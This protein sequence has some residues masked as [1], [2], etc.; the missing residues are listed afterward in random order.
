MSKMQVVGLGA[1]NMDYLY[2]VERILT[3]GETVVKDLTVAPG[4]SAANT[5]YGL[6]KLGVKTGFVGAVGDDADG[7]ALVQDFQ[8]VGIDTRRIK[9]KPKA[10]SGAVLCLTDSLGRRS[11]Y[12]SPGANSLLSRDDL[13]LGY[14]NQAQIL[15][16]TSFADEAQFQISLELIDKLKPSIKLSFSLG[17]LYT[18]RKLKALKPIISKAHVL[19]MNHHEI[20]QLTGKDMVAGAE[21]CLKLGCRIVVVTLGKGR[22]LELSTG[23]IDNAVCYIR[24]TE[25]EYA[26]EASTKPVPQVDATGA[27]DAFAAGFLYGLLNGK[28]L[29]EC[30]RLG[31]TVARFVIG[32]LGTRAG[33]PTPKEL[34]QSYK[35]LY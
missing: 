20:E 25:N 9:I 6:A 23:T 33:L 1:L 32:K 3:D 34:A 2:R 11:L 14:I 35:R 10:R 8:S 17:A 5:A 18:V 30:G 27:G 4:G 16:V 12:V 28:R 31:D 29:E 22:R 19:F 13:D 7:E 21:T 26:V 15:H 24:D